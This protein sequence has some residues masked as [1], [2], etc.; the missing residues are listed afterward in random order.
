M[1]AMIFNPYNAGGL[2]GQQELMQNTWKMTETLAHG[3]SSENTLQELSNEYHD[4]V[5]MFFKNLY[6]LALWTKVAS[7]LEGLNSW[8]YLTGFPSLPYNVILC[9]KLPFNG[10]DIIP[11]AQCLVI[12]FITTSVSFNWGDIIT[13]ITRIHFVPKYYDFVQQVFPLMEKM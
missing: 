4:R 8:E 7:V 9:D 3:L 13:E 12:W 1:Q 2:F 11:F 10:G 6:I 5:Q